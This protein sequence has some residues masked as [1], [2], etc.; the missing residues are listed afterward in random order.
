MK[1]DQVYVFHPGCHQT[2]QQKKQL[3]CVGEDLTPEVFNYNATG[4]ALLK[5]AEIRK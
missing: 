2:E 4:T 1:H 5:N 3:G